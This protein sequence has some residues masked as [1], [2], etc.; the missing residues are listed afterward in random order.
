MTP[1][2]SLRRRALV[3]VA[4]TIGFYTLALALAVTLLF[5]SYAQIAWSDD[6][7]NRGLGF[8][9]PTGVKTS[10]RGRGIGGRLVRAS[11]TDLKRLGHRKAVIPWT[12]ALDFYA[13]CCGAKPAHQFIALDSRP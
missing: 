5:L 2:A 3:A 1:S 9:G 4:L 7:N 13:K 8:F 6:V 11:L 12:D 10:L